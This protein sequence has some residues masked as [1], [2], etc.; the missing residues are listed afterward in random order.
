M[1]PTISPYTVRKS[2]VGHFRLKVKFKVNAIKCIDVTYFYLKKYSRSQ[3][4]CCGS[5][6][7]S[8]MMNQHNDYWGSIL[9]LFSFF[10][11]KTKMYVTVF[12]CLC[13]D[14]QKREEHETTFSLPFSKVIRVGLRFWKVCI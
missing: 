4:L 10:S 1:C 7:K 11:V 3:I 2:Q 5:N 9:F 6:K 13:F 8:I 12:I 14:T